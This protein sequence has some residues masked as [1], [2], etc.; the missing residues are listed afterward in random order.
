MPAGGWCQCGKGGT[1]GGRCGGLGWDLPFGRKA[2]AP[3]IERLTPAVPLMTQ[4]LEKPAAH[5]EIVLA[6]RE[7]EPILENLLELYSHDFSEHQEL[8]IGTDGRFGY[9]WLPLYWS[10][11]NRYPF[12]VRMN[13]TLAGLVFVK[14]GSEVSGHEAIWD[15]AEF[16]ILRGY[17]RRGIGTQTAHEVFRHFP[18]VWEV[19]VM[20]SNVSASHFWARAIS[21]FTGGAIHP[22]RVKKDTKLWELYSFESKLGALP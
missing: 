3:I 9:K 15:M 13:G 14:R 12:L 6:T 11:P 22:A 16:F 18:G 21:S 19:R 8:S 7:Q 1:D 17:R 2:A 20:P 10:E 5:L 4:P